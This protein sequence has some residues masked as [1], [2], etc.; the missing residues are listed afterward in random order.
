MDTL[1]QIKTEM[2]SLMERIGKIE[3]TKTDGTF[4]FTKDQLLKFVH[5]LGN[6][7]IEEIK[8][9]IIDESFDFEDSVEI[10]FDTYNKSFEIIVDEQEIKKQIRDSIED[11]SIIDDDFI[12]HSAELNTKTC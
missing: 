11:L 10:E 2:I 12:I 8:V 7:I 1:E 4:T 5:Q 6:V 9:N 3:V